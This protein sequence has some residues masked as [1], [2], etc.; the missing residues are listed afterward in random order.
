MYN[1][2]MENETT[3]EQE[4]NELLDIDYFKILFDP[5]RIE[6]IIYLSENGPKNI[7]E[8]A[9]NFSQDRSVISRHLDILYKKKILI[10]RKESRFVI[11]EADCW[12]IINK[13]EET[14]NNLKALMK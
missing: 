9:E 13:F 5:V 14:T 6:I 2:T 8:I 1:R 11:Y 12:G 10:K 7:G 3:C 4:V